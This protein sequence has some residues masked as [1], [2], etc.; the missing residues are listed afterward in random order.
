MSHGIRFGQVDSSRCEIALAGRLH[1]DA[2]HE[3]RAMLDEATSRA[4][5]VLLDASDLDS[6]DA[7]ALQAVVDA[8]KA[9][10]RR[11]GVVVFFG[12]RPPVLQ[13]LELT[14]VDRL[15]SMQATR[16]DALRAVA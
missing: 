10:R 12:A 11:G 16:A 4:R 9:L 1:G 6:I 3:L 2:A 5:V 14:G 13:L 7:M 15:V 8:V